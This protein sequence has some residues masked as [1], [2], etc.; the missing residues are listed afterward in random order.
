MVIIGREKVSTFNI[1]LF[2]FEMVSFSTYEISREGKNFLL[3]CRI[4]GS[5]GGKS[6]LYLQRRKVEAD[7]EGFKIADPCRR[8]RRR[9]LACC[10]NISCWVN[11]A[12][13]P[14]KQKLIS[15][16]H[17]NFRKKLKAFVDA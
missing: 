13:W 16:Q 12:T 1:H 8:R 4:G 7:L 14:Q 11:A 5:G 9:R 10:S 3:F 15:H 17:T 2:C 6:K